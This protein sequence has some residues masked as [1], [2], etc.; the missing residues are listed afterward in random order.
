[1]GNNFLAHFFILYAAAICL[2]SPN[3]N[4]SIIIFMD[5][6]YLNKKPSASHLPA[7]RQASLQKAFL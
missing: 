3:N 5:Q 1:Y 7:S 4:V 6:L 2:S